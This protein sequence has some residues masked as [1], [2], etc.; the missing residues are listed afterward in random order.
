[1][2]AGKGRK[3]GGEESMNRNAKVDAARHLLNISRQDGPE[4]T[5]KQY[6]EMAKIWHPDVNKTE[7]AHT[8]MQ[9][10]NDAFAFL[11]EEEFG[12]LDF[13]DD[14]ERWWW[15]EYGNDPIWGNYYPEENPVPPD[16]IR[17]AIKQQTGTKK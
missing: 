9:A 17:K 3:A 13:R 12:I 10:I 2:K 14:Y 5:K 15:R 16:S 1:M 6:R 8:R 7:E 4:E 11:M